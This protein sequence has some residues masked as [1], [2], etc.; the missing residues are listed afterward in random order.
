MYK[1]GKELYVADTLS[2]AALKENCAVELESE[3][4][5]R[6]ELEQMGLK[7]ATMS[8][9]TLNKM[10]EETRK[11][12]T[13]KC[14]LETVRKGWPSDKLMLPPCIRQYWFFREEITLYEGVLLKTHQVIVPTVLRK[15]MLEKIH[16]SHQGADSSISRAREAL[17]WPGMS[18]NIR[19]MS[20][21]CGICAQFQTEQPREP[22]KSHEIPKLPWS[23]I[24]VD[25]FQLAGKNY[26]VMVDH[27]S[28]FIEL[29]HLKNTTA[30]SVIKV[31]KKNFAR[32]GIPSECVSD[33][34]PQFDSSEYRSFAREYGFTPVKSSPYYSQ[35]NGKAELAVK[36]AKNILKKS[37]NE[38][39]YLALLAYRNTPQQGYVYS[40]A[41][42]LMARKLKDIIPMVPSQL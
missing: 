23:R 13:L 25:L 1:R 6:V 41:E 21:A 7:P 19:Q 34:G 10:K 11:D 4:V 27:Y 31:M 8:D 17:F 28:D 42:R 38:D 18:A 30:N 2:R 3:M 20:E 33:N 40:P 15:E 26:L 36:V 14:L 22:M 37:D 24:S 35:G 9:C 16:K 5:F 29:D 32:H 12:Q 39:S